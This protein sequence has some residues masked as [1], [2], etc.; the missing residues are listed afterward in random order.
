MNGDMGSI[1][2][3]RHRHESMKLDLLDAQP[4]HVAAHA[5]GVVRHPSII[6]RLVFEKK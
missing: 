6:R 1:R 4:L 5:G 2:F 3:S